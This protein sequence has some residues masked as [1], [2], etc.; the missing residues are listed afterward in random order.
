MMRLRAAQDVWLFVPKDA[1]FLAS[2]PIGAEMCLRKLA[3][4]ANSGHCV[5]ITAATEYSVEF[6]EAAY[7]G[8]SAANMAAARDASLKTEDGTESSTDATTPA[9]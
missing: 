2:P 5:P 4:F 6:P 8:D 1:E 3:S 7:L 9:P